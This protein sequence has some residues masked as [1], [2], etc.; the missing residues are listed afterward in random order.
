MRNIMASAAEE[1]YGTIFINS[2]TAVPIR[3]NLSEMG[4]PQ[5]LTA[6]QVENS[7][8]VGI[9]TKEL[10]QKNSKT[11]GMRFYRINARIEQGQFCVFWRPAPENLGDYHSKHHTP[12]HHRAVRSKYLHVPNLHSLQ[13]C[14]NLTVR[15]NPTKRESQREKLER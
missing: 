9:P 14:V 10:H 7:T 6:I 3:T 11:M 1:E 15:V 4:W 5:G 13:G 8:A 12:E 2:Q